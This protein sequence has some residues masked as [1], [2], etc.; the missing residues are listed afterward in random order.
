MEPPPVVTRV[1]ALAPQPAAG[2][3]KPAKATSADDAREAAE[4]F[5]AMFL[6]QV[7]N[8]MFSGIN[9]KGPFGGGFGEDV[10]RSVLN[11]EFAK[12][13][14]AGARLDIADSVLREILKAQ[15]AAE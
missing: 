1:P 11:E 7:L 13:I 14:G 5:E 15:E 12:A 2:E 8:S 3:A 10:Y 6:A 4:S 9:T